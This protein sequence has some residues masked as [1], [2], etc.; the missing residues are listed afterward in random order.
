[1]QEKELRLAIVYFGG[2]SLAIYQHG[3]NVEILNLL[4]A[5]RAFHAPQHFALR[6]ASDRSYAAESG[7]E[8][9]GETVS[10]EAVYFDLLKE[11]G[12]VVDLRII[13]DVVSGS[14]AGGINAAVM[15]RAIAHDFSI[16]PLTAMW[17]DKADILDLITPEA[18]AGKWSKWY[19]APVMKAIFARLA[20]EGI[21][22]RDASR[23][24]RRRLM[25][26]VR[27]RWFK[28]PFDG[29]HFC[30][31]L[32]DGMLAMERGALTGS[33]LLPPE[34][35]LDLRISVTDYY[36]AD[37]LIFMHDPAVV[38]ER[39]HRQMLH[40]AAVRPSSGRIQSDF[41]GSNVPSL[42][43]AARA[44]ASYP[45]AFPPAQIREMAALVATRGL[46]WS[47]KDQFLAN[48]FSH[49]RQIG[50]EPEDAVL[51]DGSVLNNKP[52]RAAI[53]ALRSHAAYREVDRRL[54]FIDPHPEHA[55]DAPGLQMPGFFT[56]LRRA[57][58]DLPRH[59]PIYEELDETNRFNEQVASLK[60]L[61][62][63]SRTN[64][65]ALIERATHGGLT[66][67]F[68][69]AQVLHW[70][71][72]SSNLLAS[73][74]LTYNAWMGSL[75]R[76]AIELISDLLCR[77]CDLDRRSQHAHWVRYVIEAW[78]EAAGMFPGDYVIP[79]T[80]KVDA[81][82]P[83]FAQFVVNFGVRY[84]ARRI[85]HVLH[86]I[87]ATYQLD[88]GAFSPPLNFDLVDELKR[89]VGNSLRSLYVFETPQFL[90]KLPAA[91]IRQL[92]CPPESGPRPHP[93]QFVSLR[94][95]ELTDL[96]ASIG[97]VCGLAGIS[98]DLDDIM[99]SPLVM[100]LHPKLR[101]AVLSG[102]LGWPYSD[103]VLLPAINAL[104]LNGN[105]FEEVLVDRISPKDARSICI[106][107]DCAPLRGEA[108]IGF[109]GF[110]DRASRQNDYLW[111]RIHAIDRLIDIVA[112]T[113][114]TDGDANLLD[115]AAFK[116]LAFER[117]LVDEGDR[118]ADVADIVEAVR[119][120]V[121]KL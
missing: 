20:R 43:F 96:F 44:S 6:H 17:F 50:L 111:G 42:A 37:K 18:R 79:D 68:T 73:S 14:S 52:V 36:G 66:G 103:I 88:A 115:I 67:T 54:V 53:D 69:A 77:T 31:L 61:A 7:T 57:L 94:G 59:E 19:V 5:S 98:G 101:E 12:K 70:R 120:A 45:G 83:P 4:R 86:E 119:S 76:E 47:G 26:F 10:T 22:P 34:T 35:R 24:I 89:Q 3:V 72:T 121:A 91:T 39:E 28:P 85:A 48:N 58:S 108:A 112:S 97:T 15:A 27:S 21:L 113:V 51:L 11:V 71:L 87:N 29:P 81:E 16:A 106:D 55:T 8:R 105:T 104:G 99:S 33:T 109:G 117:M 49:Y 114:D 2:V 32:L 64:V 60:S 40:F 63:S 116:K 107:P 65:Q 90:Q 78:C 80:V 13:V 38:R 102:Y 93:I 100:S 75:V 82:L 95:T 1:V 23:D 25:T 92:F 84:K 9:P 118:L 62:R 46:D 30:G 110:L 56:T 41:D 74:S